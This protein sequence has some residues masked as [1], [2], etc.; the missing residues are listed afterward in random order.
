MGLSNHGLSKRS[1]RVFGVHRHRS[2]RHAHLPTAC[3]TSPSALAHQFERG[4]EQVQLRFDRFGGPLGPYVAH[5]QRALSAV[6][7][8]SPRRSALA[9]VQS[10]ASQILNVL[11]FFP[12]PRKN[13]QITTHERKNIYRICLFF[14]RL[15]HL[16]STPPILS[17]EASDFAIRGGR[18]RFLKTREEPPCRWT[19]MHPRVFRHLR[20]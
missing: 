1:E 18:D 12:D 15:V 19:P 3:A 2:R 10:H 6:T 9:A 13:L 14:L 20:S 5:A 8:P 16:F 7:I 4:F 17:H 11:G